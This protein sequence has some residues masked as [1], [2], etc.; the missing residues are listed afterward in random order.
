M[1]DYSAQ[2][3]KGGGVSHG[4]LETGTRLPF[5]NFGFKKKKGYESIVRVGAKVELELGELFCLFAKL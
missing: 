1:T 4:Y 5:E 3:G 2:A